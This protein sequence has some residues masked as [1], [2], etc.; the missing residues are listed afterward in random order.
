VR[1]IDPETHRIYTKLQQQLDSM[2]V[3][4]AEIDAARTDV[5]STAGV[6]RELNEQI[7]LKEQQLAGLKGKKAAKV[8]AELDALRAQQQQLAI[9]QDTDAR[10][11]QMRE[12][13]LRTEMQRLDYEMRDLA[14]PMSRARAAAEGRLQ[15]PQPDPE[16]L[17]FIRGRNPGIEELY[18][19]SWMK[20]A[21]REQVTPR[22]ATVD[23]MVP[24]I[25]DELTPQ[26]VRDLPPNAD[27]AE[28]ARIVLAEQAKRA[29]EALE[30]TRAQIDTLRGLTDEMDING[31][32]Y[33]LDDA[34]FQIMVPTEDGHKA[35][36]LRQMLDDIADDEASL[37]AVSSC[38]VRKTS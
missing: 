12:T 25:N 26:A 9:P 29:D 11:L 28:K 37:K 31:V 27:A 16:V 2:R 3:Q 24:G 7:A 15:G 32:K 13:I 21:P 36:T 17:D 19:P 38:S 8:Q 5:S 14:L 10:A 33:K 23:E 35:M 34:D 20:P 4:L 1:R 30:V 18:K 22:A 6:A